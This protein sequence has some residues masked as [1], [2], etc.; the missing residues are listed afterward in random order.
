M[1]EELVPPGFEGWY[2]GARVFNLFRNDK[3]V[4]LGTFMTGIIFMT[5]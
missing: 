5:C 3:N 1:M 2:E 4:M